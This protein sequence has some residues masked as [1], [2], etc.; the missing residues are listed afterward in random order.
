MPHF[1]S[2]YP[3]AQKAH[4]CDDCGRTIDPGEKYQRGVGLDG[5]AWTWKRCDHCARLVESLDEFEDET[6]LADY[7]EEPVDLAQAREFAGFQHRWRTQSGK[8]W[9]SPTGRPFLTT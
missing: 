1:V 3:T 7:T 5:T 4:R 8:L 6:C 2:T 9:P